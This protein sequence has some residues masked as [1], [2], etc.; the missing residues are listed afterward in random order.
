MSGSGVHLILTRN[1]D[2]S[3]SDATESTGASDSGFTLELGL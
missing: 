3:L 2:L 1:A